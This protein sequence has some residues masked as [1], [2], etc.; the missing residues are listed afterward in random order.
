[1][2]SCVAHLTAFVKANTF[3]EFPTLQIDCNDL[4]ETTI[5]SYE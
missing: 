5:K 1:M 3:L 2:L 4:L